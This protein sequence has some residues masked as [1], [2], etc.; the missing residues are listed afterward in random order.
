M[1]L[2]TT[3]DCYGEAYPELFL[4]VHGDIRVDVAVRLGGDRSPCG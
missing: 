2:A 3:L 1:Y 4:D